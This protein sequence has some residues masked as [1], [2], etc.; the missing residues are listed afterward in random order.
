MAD[1]AILSQTVKTTF[2]MLELIWLLAVAVA[3]SSLAICIVVATVAA[4]R[5]Y[6]RR[7]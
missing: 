6:L 4:V 7:D 1:L 3:Y 5:R 2:G